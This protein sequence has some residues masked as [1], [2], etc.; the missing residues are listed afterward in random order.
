[1]RR[2]WLPLLLALVAPPAV[3]GHTI[4]ASWIVYGSDDAPTMTRFDSETPWL[5]ENPFPPETEVPYASLEFDPVTRQLV[6][7]EY[8]DCPSARC[9][10][11]R[12]AFDRGHLRGGWHLR[13]AAQVSSC[14]LAAASLPGEAPKNR[15]YSRLNCDGLS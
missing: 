9:Q 5:Q 7:F 13:S 11:I 12:N 10:P 1:M 6:G 8:F 14:F 2:T 3:R 15:A 4:Y